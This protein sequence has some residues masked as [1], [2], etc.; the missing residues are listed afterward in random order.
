MERQRHSVREGG[1]TETLSERGGRER[2][3]DSERGGGRETKT[4]SERGGERQRQ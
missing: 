4:L 3:R 1:E 2:D